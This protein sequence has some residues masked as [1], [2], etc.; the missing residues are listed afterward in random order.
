MLADLNLPNELST[1]NFD[2]LI[3]DHYS[4][5]GKKFSKL[6]SRVRFQSIV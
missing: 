3:T 4:A 2:D 1:V 5:Y 6:A